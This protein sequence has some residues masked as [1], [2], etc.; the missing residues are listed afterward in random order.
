M[1]LAAQAG[2]RAAAR[3]CTGIGDPPRLG[4]AVLGVAVDPD[5]VEGDAVP[6]GGHWPAWQV[7]GAGMSSAASPPA[8]NPVVVAELVVQRDPQVR[9][10]GAEERSLLLDPARAQQR[11]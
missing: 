3:A 7:Q 1:P 6:R 9:E 4:N 11:R 10:R 5:F 8:G 2:G